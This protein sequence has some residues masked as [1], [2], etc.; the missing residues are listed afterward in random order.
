MENLKKFFSGRTSRVNPNLARTVTSAALGSLS[1][2]ERGSS[3]ALQ[4]A[5]IAK[6]GYDATKFLRVRDSLESRGYKEA[7]LTVNGE[8]RESLD[9]TTELLSNTAMV[10]REEDFISPSKFPYGG[11]DKD[12]SVSKVLNSFKS[13]EIGVM[14]SR[15]FF[16]PY[17]IVNKL[18]NREAGYSVAEIE[19]MYGQYLAF[20][21]FNPTELID[22]KEM[23]LEE[24]KY[25]GY[26]SSRTIFGSGGARNLKFSTVFDAS[27]VTS[28]DR[29]DGMFNGFEDNAAYRLNKDIVSSKLSNRDF[30]YFGG[31]K[32]NGT[33]AAVNRLVQLSRP[34]DFSDA[35]EDVGRF[36][37]SRV[38]VEIDNSTQYMHELKQTKFFRN[39][40][41]EAARFEP[42][43][44]LYFVA[45]K[46]VYLGYLKSPEVRHTTLIKDA[47]PIRTEVDIN[48][49]VEEWAVNKTLSEDILQKINIFA[50]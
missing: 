16:I 41:E 46:Y 19:K 50:Q 40:Y 8:Y 13:K 4:T 23:A 27:E 47:V 42:T 32:S 49:V 25:L 2:L 15:F 9:L 17:A 29:Q 22:T 7:Y 5:N 36:A 39:L 18:A 11:S 1:A 38:G 3:A 12:T 10:E 24:R 45:G 28:V 26:G 43:P 44:L 6:F 33:M 30:A 21:Q 37:Y 48:F 35:S 20:L 31:D 14:N 34:I